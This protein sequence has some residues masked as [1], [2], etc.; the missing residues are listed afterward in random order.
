[1]SIFVGNIIANDFFTI[2]G[3][4]LPGYDLKLIFKIQFYNTSNR[5]TW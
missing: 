5:R 4:S 1:M 2:V 3:Y